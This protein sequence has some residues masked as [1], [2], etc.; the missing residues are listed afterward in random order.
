MR[1]VNAQWKYTVVNKIKVEIAY[2]TPSMQSIIAVEVTEGAS[3][4]EAIDLSGILIIFPEINLE[5][6]QVGIFSQ[7][8]NLTDIVSAHDRIEIYRPL[9]IDPKKAR[10]ARALNT[11]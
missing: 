11:L 6:Q 7:P 8:K 5:Q 1:F 3:I 10:R 4:Q 9:L 2:A